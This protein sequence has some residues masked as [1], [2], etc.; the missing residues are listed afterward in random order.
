M[1]SLSKSTTGR[2][3]HVAS[4]ALTTADHTGDTLELPG[5]ADRSIQFSGTWGGATA[6]IEGSNDGST[7]VALPD[8]SS[9]EIA[10]TTDALKAVLPNVRYIRPR[11]TTVGAGATITATLISKTG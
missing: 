8:P 3:T 11:L 9:T 4:W 2:S 6:K 5:A 7:F 1:A 10:A